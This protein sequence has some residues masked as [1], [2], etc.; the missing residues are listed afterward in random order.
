M[1]VSWPRYRLKGLVVVKCFPKGEKLRYLLVRNNRELGELRGGRRMP[2]GRALGWEKRSAW[3]R[4]RGLARQSRPPSA[5]LAMP[6]PSSPVVQK[7][8][9]DLTRR[10]SPDAATAIDRLACF[11]REP[12]KRDDEAALIENNGL[13]DLT[14]G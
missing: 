14:E 10:P 2:N 1:S 12:P 7:P 8:P 9:F 11:E 4:A 5:L 3:T 6:N 13:S